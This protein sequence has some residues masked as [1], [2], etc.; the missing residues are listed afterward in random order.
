M[1]DEVEEV[2][3]KVVGSSVV[4]YLDVSTTY[5]LPPIV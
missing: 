4:S 5:Q 1:I 3:G 2:R